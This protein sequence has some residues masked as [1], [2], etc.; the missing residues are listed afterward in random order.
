MGELVEAQDYCMKVMQRYIDILDDATYMPNEHIWKE[1]EYGIPWRSEFKTHLDM[2]I[3]K[4]AKKALGKE[5]ATDLKDKDPF[6][7]L[8]TIVKKDV[9]DAAVFD[10]KTAPELL[11]HGLTQLEDL[12][13]TVSKIKCLLKEPDFKN[14]KDAQK[15]AKKHLEHKHEQFAKDYPH[16]ELDGKKKK[17]KDKEE[18]G[19]DETKK[20]K[21]AN[22]S[23][24]KRKSKSKKKDSKSKSKKKDKKKG[25]K[26]KDES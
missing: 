18:R 20:E 2:I 13:K 5:T 10:A 3:K 23:D 22:D 12:E 21:H 15:K 25:S 11:S 16:K 17:K 26:S 19:R 7:L 6:V 4:L 24:K 1:K 14:F 9:V 8:H